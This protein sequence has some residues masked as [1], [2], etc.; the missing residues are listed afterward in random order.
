MPEDFENNITIKKDLVLSLDQRLTK[1]RTLL[2]DVV[3]MSGVT[4][5]YQP[6]EK[7]YE[8]T[9]QCLQVLLKHGY[10]VHIITKSDL[11]LRDLDLLQA[12]AEKNWCTVSVTITT[13][14][15]AK[16]RFLE[17][18]SPIPEKRFR[19]IEEI[20]AKAPNIQT[21]VLAMP[22]VPY[23]SD[24]KEE[25]EKLYQ[26]TKETKADYLIFAAGMTIHDTQAL[27]FLSHISKEFP[28][29][30]PG[31]EKLYGLKYDSKQYLGSMIPVESYMKEKIQMLLELNKKYE[32]PYRIKRFIPKDHRH[33]N[34][35]VAEKLLNEAYDLQLADKPHEN[36]HW[37]GQNIQNLDIP[38]TQLHQFGQL[39]TI[40]NLEGD[41]LRK[42]GTML[43]EITQ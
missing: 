9:R 33:V 28:D 25:L 42:V 16:A 38:I 3:A 1:A 39:N 12:I 2:P 23:L 29:L 41:I 27:Y 40:R 17:K 4:D 35:Q 32:L 15:E 10:P 30:I 31:Y 18:R 26:R 43:K 14:D 19:I 8:N 13:T 22:I 6:A 34:Y 11:V 5:P 37:A 7:K 21:G 20:K 24:N 36:I